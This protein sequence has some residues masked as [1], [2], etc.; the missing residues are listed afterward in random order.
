MRVKWSFTLCG[1]SFQVHG[2]GIGEKL[3]QYILDVLHTEQRVAI[4]HALSS[5]ANMYRSDQI[6][7]EINSPKEQFT[8][9]H[10]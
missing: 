6:R 4:E 10:A 2:W 5:I 3:K 7:S 1:V 9:C 8:V